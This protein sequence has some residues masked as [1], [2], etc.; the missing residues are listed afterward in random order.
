M[1]SA[2]SQSFDINKEHNSALGEYITSFKDTLPSLSAQEALIQYQ[3][4]HGSLQ[5]QEYLTY[6][7]NAEPVWLILPIS[8]SSNTS[9]NKRVSIETSW[10]DS[11]DIYLFTNKKPAVSY[12]H[13]RAHET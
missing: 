7:I 12:T 1:T 8:N 5:T 4:G 10:L 3:Q 6:G 13:L 11:V 9:I 2:Y